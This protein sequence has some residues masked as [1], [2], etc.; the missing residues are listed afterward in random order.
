MSRK[1]KVLVAMSG[2]VDSSVTA[3]LLKEEGCEV[4]GVTMKIWAGEGPSEE[5][6]RHACYGPGE[7]EDIKDAM[8][9][10]EKLDIPFHVFDLREDYRAS[11]LDYTRD[12]Y[13]SGRTPNPCIRCNRLVKLGALL[14]SV[15]DSGL[16]YDSV[17]TG[18]YVR[19]KFDDITK[20]HL[21]MKAR[22]ATKDQSYILY[23]LSQEQLGISLFPLGEYTK[24]EVRKKAQ[25]ADLGISD[26]IESQDFMAGGHS[27]LFNTTAKPGPVLDL[28]GRTLGEHKGIPFYTIGQR[29]GLGI[30]AGK[31]LYVIDINPGKNEVTVGSRENL[32]KSECTATQLNWISIESLE[33]PIRVKAKIRYSHEEAD[34]V[35]T[36]LA[37]DTL[38]VRFEEPQMAITPGQ[39]IV[40]YD[41]DVV[42][43]GGTI[44][45]D[46]SSTR[47][48]SVGGG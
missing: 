42:V 13:L 46:S 12:E 9:V 2:G 29:R 3:L 45:Q 10:A 40:F 16:D 47:K 41:R 30:P 38:K 24:K 44:E 27:R 15:R 4:I 21:L 43:G 25:D 11:V 8:T 33:E 22:D 23:S 7:P 6:V 36:L 1:K 14:A 35:I 17:A 18:H 20:R 31:P 37:G 26:K 5:G 48:C 32:F 39:A 34:A 19:V 28:R